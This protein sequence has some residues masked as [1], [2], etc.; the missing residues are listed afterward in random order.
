MVI[1]IIWALL[2]LVVAAV[3]L[4]IFV[5]RRNRAQAKAARAAWQAAH[6]TLPKNYDMGIALMWVGLI[7]AAGAI[8][9]QPLPYFMTSPDVF[10]GLGVALAIWTVIAGIHFCAPTDLAV[11]AML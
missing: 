2:C 9:G 8:G 1:G 4:L 6:P 5:I 11:I 3:L 7:C 10:S